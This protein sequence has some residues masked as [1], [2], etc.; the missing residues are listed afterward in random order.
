MT[1]KN[2]LPCGS[3]ISIKFCKRGF[4]YEAIFHAGKGYTCATSKRFDDH[5]RPVRASY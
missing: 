4:I 1:I 2:R 5:F 3:D